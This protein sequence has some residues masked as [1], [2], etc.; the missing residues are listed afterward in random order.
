MENAAVVNYCTLI[1]RRNWSSNSNG[2]P[3]PPLS[4]WEGLKN[5]P[6]RPPMIGMAHP[7]EYRNKVQ[8]PFALENGRVI[9]GCYQQGTHNVIDTGV[10]D[11]APAEQQDHE[12]RPRVGGRDGDL[13]L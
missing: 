6:V 7:W 3:T 12:C 5:L 2:V 13:Y 4:G 11:P 9:V 8:Y 10:L 1:T